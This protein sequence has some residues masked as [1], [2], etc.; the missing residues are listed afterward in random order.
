[1][2]IGVGRLLKSKWGAPAAA[3]AATGLAIHSMHPVKGATDLALN[4]AFGD[5]QTNGEDVD[6]MILGRDLRPRE[7]FGGAPWDNLPGF[8]QAYNMG[9]RVQSFKDAFSPLALSNY[10]YYDT[11]NGVNQLS[12]SYQARA[13][14][15]QSAS[16]EVATL[17]YT[18][19]AYAAGLMD[20]PYAPKTRRSGVYAQGDMV[21]GMYNSRFGPGRFG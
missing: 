18:D 3:L 11:I 1:M 8:K 17:G 9:N 20:L 4:M 2:G 19:D 16:S 14:V 13:S 15:V 12:K 7:L 5:K 10:S 6:N 21:M